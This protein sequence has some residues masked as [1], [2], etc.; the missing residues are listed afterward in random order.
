MLPTAV[1]IGCGPG[2]YREAKVISS[3]RNKYYNESNG[4]GI[5]GKGATGR[6]RAT[7]IQPDIDLQSYPRA[8]V[9]VDNTSSQEELV[10]NGDNIMVT[11]S[12]MV[13][14]NDTNT[15]SISA[16]SPERAKP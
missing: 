12:I 8:T 7:G 1:I 9:Q 16:R 10:H 14:R 5:Y 4:A 2:L 11:R 13:S 3:S 15:D 6:S